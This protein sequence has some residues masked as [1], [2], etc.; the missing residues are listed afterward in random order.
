MK[1][2]VEI[3]KEVDF[4]TYCATCKHKDK[5]EDETPCDECLAEPANV[6]S[7]KP[8]KYVEKEKTKNG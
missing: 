8:I 2:N 4:K 3:Y 6:Y 7:R 1:K 5:K